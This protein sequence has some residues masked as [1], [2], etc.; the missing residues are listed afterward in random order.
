MC[1]EQGRQI[2]EYRNSFKQFSFRDRVNIL[3]QFL[4]NNIYIFDGLHSQLF[5]EVTLC[6]LLG[7]TEMYKFH[8]FH[9]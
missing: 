9:S 2:H 7:F 6:L 4:F 1:C 5:T 3:V 8:I